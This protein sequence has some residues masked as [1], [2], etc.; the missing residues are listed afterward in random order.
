MSLRS[1]AVNDLAGLP[2]FQIDG[3]DHP[4]ALPFL[5]QLLPVLGTCGLR[6]LLVFFEG[7]HPSAE[8]LAPDRRLL[9]TAGCD[10]A[11]VGGEW[12]YLCRQAVTAG[13]LRLYLS[14]LSQGY[15]LVLLAGETG[16]NLPILRLQGGD[17][18]ADRQGESGRIHSISPMAGVSACAQIIA[19]LL[20]EMCRQVPVWACVLIGGRSSRMG[21]AKHLLSDERGRTWLENT[22]ALLAPLVEEVVLSGRGL[23]PESLDDLNRIADIP[24]VAGPLAGI[25][26]AMRWRPEVSWLLVACDMPALSSEALEWL[27]DSRR[28]GCWGTVPRTSPDSHVEPLLAHYDRRC[29]SIFEEVLAS[30]SLRIGEAASH[31]KIATPVIPVQLRRAWANI[32]TP[33][34]LRRTGL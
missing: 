10:I 22:V 1:L 31:A 32:N 28:P 6:P 17:S 25:L 19:D 29:R 23:I 26:S 30:G 5:G 18:T 34:E 16:L 20:G 24:G 15:D 7:Q 2:V 4:D 11:S 14:E 13:P 12:L 9:F 21:R 8:L 3:L 33:E 27:I